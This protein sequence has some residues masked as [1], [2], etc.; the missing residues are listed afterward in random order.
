MDR[1]KPKVLVLDANQR[2]ALAVTRSL[3]KSS[4]YQISSADS[5]AY[6]L[7]GASRYSQ[8]YYRY[9]DPNQQPQEFINWI[10]NFSASHHF[11][12][13]M[14]TTE[15]TS[16]L[17][18]MFQKELP[19][20][21]LPFAA[22]SN[23]MA[24]ADKVTLVELARKL[25]IAIPESEVYHS[26]DQVVVDRLTFPVVIKPALSRI[27]REGRWIHTQVRIAK[28]AAD[29]DQIVS[30][31]DYL[32]YAP[33]MLQEFI[34][35]HGSGIFCIYDNGTPVQF[36]A[37]QRLREKPPEGGVSVLS[38]SIPVPEDLRSVA[39][40]LLGAVDWHG[41]AM[42]E[43]RV[44]DEGNPYLM[45]VNTRFWGSLQLA[46]DAG[47]D[48]PLMLAN[49]HLKRPSVA[50][51][52]YRDNQRLRWL[53]GDLDSLYIFIKSSHPIRKKLQRILSFLSIRFHGQKHEINRL[54]DIKPAWVELKQYL[55]S[56]R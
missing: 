52:A 51:N 20:V 43:F 7:A 32:D 15:V 56:L 10:R 50:L 6:A 37:H 14:P 21:E 23:V 53:L 44:S 19:H 36:F 26:R 45:E 34:P 1:D 18:L 46:I 35:G 3:G 28:N 42:V 54:S 38:R 41:V 47:V 2:S 30:D 13:Y 22:Y 9:P 12:L 48:F 5:V 40:R 29:W 11:D 55:R 25:D 4:Q 24:L 27:Y 16:Q 49:L 31:M 39:E 8:T 33:F 17:L